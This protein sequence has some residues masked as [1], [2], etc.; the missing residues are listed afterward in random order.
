MNTTFKL[1]DFEHWLRERGY[2]RMMGE[3]NLRAYLNLGFASLL[4]SNSHL[5]F[6]FILS[7]FELPTVGEREKIRFEIAKKVKSIFASKEELKIEL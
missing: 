2:D 4:F 7:S 6:S 1:K 3:Q 5:L